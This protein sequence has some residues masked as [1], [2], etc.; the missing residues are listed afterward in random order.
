MIKVVGGTRPDQHLCSTCEHALCTKGPTES[1]DKTFCLVTKIHTNNVT[2]CNKYEGPGSARHAM[3][4]F[5]GIPPGMGYDQTAIRRFIAG[6]KRGEFS[7]RP[8]SRVSRRQAV[9]VKTNPTL[10]VQ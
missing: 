5:S 4:M 6:R 10:G 7:L 2:S 1:S 9:A 8:K 3:Q